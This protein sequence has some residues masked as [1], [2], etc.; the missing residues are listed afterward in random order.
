MKPW[1]LSTRRLRIAMCLLVLCSVAMLFVIMN[2]ETLRMYMA[3]LRVRSDFPVDDV[4]DYDE[5]QIRTDLR[6]WS[7]SGITLD[8]VEKAWKSNPN[9]IRVMIIDNVLYLQDLKGDDYRLGS[10][11]YMMYKI[12]QKHQLPNVDFVVNFGDGNVLLNEFDVPLFSFYNH[13]DYGD[14][15][16][17]NPCAFHWIFQYGEVMSLNRQ[18][19]WE[20]KRDQLVWR[21]TT[22]GGYYQPDNWRTFARSK[23]V[24]LTDESPDL[25]DAGFVGCSQCSSPD[26]VPVSEQMNLEEQLQ[27]KLLI[28]V[29]GNTAPSSR[30]LW[31]YASNSAVLRQES[32]F[33]EFF[34]SR[35]KPWTHF[36]P[37]KPDMSDVVEKV[38]WAL[39]NQK[40][41]K[42]IADRST[43]LV[44]EHL[45]PEQLLCYYVS[46]VKSYAALLR[47]EPQLV[48]GMLP[49]TTAAWPRVCW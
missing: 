25:I 31:S 2:F 30:S 28:L 24:M 35:L 40:R 19:E 43:R 16:L 7:E 37:V 27:Y 9:N 5:P 17:P 39:D 12:L 29:D 15:V 10:F 48:D 1:R 47:Y 8:R 21:G 23:L 13:E 34:Y 26:V 20:S 22:T 36:I 11:R 45:R 49:V 14:L 3:V 44:R 46:A 38:Q 32:P 33:G 18:I 41:T 6:R 4:C 42:E